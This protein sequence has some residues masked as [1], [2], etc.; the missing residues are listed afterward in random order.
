MPGG[1]ARADGPVSA[2]E[3]ERFLALARGARDP[4]RRASAGAASQFACER[5][6]R[7]RHRNIEFEIAAHDDVAG[8]SVVRSFRIRRRLRRN[9]ERRPGIGRESEATRAYPVAEAADR[10]ALTRKAEFRGKRHS[11]ARFGHGSV[12]INTPACGRYRARNARTANGTSY[13]SHAC[14]TRSPYN[15]LTGFSSGRGH[16]GEQDSRARGARAGSARSRVRQRASRRETRRESTTLRRKT[17]A[18][19]RQNVR[20]ARRYE[21]GIRARDGQR[22]RE[23]QRQNGSAIHHSSVCAAHGPSSACAA[24]WSTSWRRAKERAHRD[25]HLID[26]GNPMLATEVRACA[27]VEET[28]CRIG[29]VAKKSRPSMCPARPRDE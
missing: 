18:N 21:T 13:G 27:P 28:P 24:R 3:N 6:C 15:A 22:H 20:S 8:A 16:V 10:R 9:A 11:A 17:A 1:N 29:S 25:D 2:S 7:V 14:I 4:E 26:A 23:A 19:R 5:A 12:S